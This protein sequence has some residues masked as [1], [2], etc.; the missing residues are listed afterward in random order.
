MCEFLLEG[1]DGKAAVTGRAGLGLAPWHDEWVLPVRRD[2]VAAVQA[3]PLVLP[4][5]VPAEG[6]LPPMAVHLSAA[7]VAAWASVR[8]GDSHPRFHAGPNQRVHPSWTPSQ[9]VYLV[10]HSCR[11]PDVGIH[12]SGRVQN[13]RPI[14]PPA[15]VV[16]AGRWTMHEQRNERWWS[17]A[18]GLVLNGEGIELAYFSQ[19]AILLPPFDLG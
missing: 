18:S 11:Q 8:A 10:R 16:V 6:D 12:V 17:G 3:P 1:P 2:P 19:V 4:E 13:L 5:H 14:T 9:Y 7:E 15:D